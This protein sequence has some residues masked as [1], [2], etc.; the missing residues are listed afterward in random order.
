[1]TMNTQLTLDQLRSMNLYGM[2]NAYEAAMTL[3]VHE[4][5]AAD[6][7]LGK[8]VDAEQL[9]E[10][11]RAQNDTCCKAKSGIQPSSNRCTATPPET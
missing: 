7:L 5:P 8:L 11:N 4:Q 2:A 10:K 3:P 1:M 6:M 9:F